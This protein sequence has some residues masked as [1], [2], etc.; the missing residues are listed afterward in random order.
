MEANLAGHIEV[1]AGLARSAAPQLDDPSARELA[2]AMIS[3]ATG[4]VLTGIDIP[5][6]SLRRRLV[7]LLRGYGVVLP[8]GPPP[9]SRPRASGPPD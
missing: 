4:S 9:G 1:V 6:D 8:P 3:L 7:A 2:S 5:P